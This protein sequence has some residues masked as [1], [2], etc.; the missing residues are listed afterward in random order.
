MKNFKRLSVLFVVL[1]LAL[2]LV[3]AVSC[4]SCSKDDGN[5]NTNTSTNTDTSADTNTDTS[6]DTNTDTSTDA[7]TDTNTDTSTDTSA[8]EIVAPEGYAIRVIDANGNAVVGAVI[9]WCDV[10]TMLDCKVSYVTDASGYVTHAD[11][12]P[13]YCVKS[14]MAD[15]YETFTGAESFTET[16]KIVT[17]IL[18]PVA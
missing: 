14:V 12:S 18:T 1:C 2:C 5:T 3:F 10:V 15:G 6:A 16:N 11:M 4:T 13:L 9:Q 7:S 8:D 17:I